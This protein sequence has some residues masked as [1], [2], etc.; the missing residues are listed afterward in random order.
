MFG[1]VEISLPLRNLK[2]LCLPLQVVDLLHHVRGLEGVAG[3]KDEN[4]NNI[5]LF[6]FFS[7]CGKSP[8]T[9]IDALKTLRR[10]KSGSASPAFLRA[11]AMPLSNA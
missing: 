8:E 9:S 11:P 7:K 6:S 3:W 10:K 4:E 1:K 2:V 5:I